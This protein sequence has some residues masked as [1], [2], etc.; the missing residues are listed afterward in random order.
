MFSPMAGDGEL[1]AFQPVARSVDLVEAGVA[2]ADVAIVLVGIT[3]LG[4]RGS[5]DMENLAGGRQGQ[6]A[7]ATRAR[8]DSD[9]VL[10]NLK[11][12]SIPCCGRVAVGRGFP[13]VAAPRLEC[14]TFIDYPLPPCS[15]KS[16]YLV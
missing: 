10:F 6:S 2:E 5:V 15:M 1:C 3:C 8:I 14:G 9:D 11:L 16:S 4:V 7:A 13:L 12:S